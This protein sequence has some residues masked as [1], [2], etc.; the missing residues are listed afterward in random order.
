VTFAAFD[1]VMSLYPHWYSTIFGVYFF[2][3]CILSFCALLPVLL[4]LL[5][6]SS[7]LSRVVSREHYHDVGKLIFAFVVFWA[8]IAF[9]QY[10]LIWYGNLPEE[11]LWYATR[12]SGPWLYVSLVLLFGHFMLPFVWLI[13]RHPKR[14][15]AVLVAASVWLLLMHWVDIYYLVMPEARPDGPVILPVDLACF[16]GLG[17]LFLAATFWM[18]GRVNLLPAR[19]PRLGESLGFENA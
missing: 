19:D 13:S 12:Q 14:R 6:R 7:G 10:M 2:A 9:S 5:G 4:A 16:V 18:L 17:G 1:L 3:G 11:T 8:Y 15:G